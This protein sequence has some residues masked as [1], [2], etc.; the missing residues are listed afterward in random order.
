MSFKGVAMKN[1]VK[2]FLFLLVLAAGIFFLRPWETSDNLA[3]ESGTQQSQVVTPHK[4]R[5]SRAPASVG[6]PGE[7]SGLSIRE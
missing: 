6:N 4:G 5:S 2:I 7:A 3:T 1:N